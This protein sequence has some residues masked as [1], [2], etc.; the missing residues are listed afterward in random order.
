M[1]F[2]AWALVLVSTTAWAKSPLLDAVLAKTQAVVNA[3]KAQPVVVFDLDATLFDNRPRNI[4]I[5]RAWAIQ[6]KHLGTPVALKVMGLKA[7]QTEYRYADTLKKIGITDKAI[8]DDFGAFWLDRFFTEW[9]VHDQAMPGGPSY[10][11]ALHKAGAFVVYLTG[12]DAPRMLTGTTQ[13]LMLWGYPLGQPRTQLIMKPHRK[14]DDEVFKDSVMS[15]LRKTGEVI[16]FFDNEPGNVNLMK[17]AFP[18]ASVIFL[19]TMHRPDAP[20]VDAG[21]PSIPDFRR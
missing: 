14:I 20:K 5:F 9:T 15:S 1:R 2:L 13:S 21:I 4:A 6:P 3:G 8:V 11:Q 16:A 10:V 7:E 18:Q 12:R 17:K 19:K